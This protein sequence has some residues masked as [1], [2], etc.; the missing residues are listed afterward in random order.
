MGTATFDPQQYKTTTR[1]QWESAAD[2][3]DR[4]DPTLTDW[5]G[6]ATELGDGTMAL[7]LDLPN[8]LEAS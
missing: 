7:I 2:A 6:G 1:A 8:L 3:W 4:W 5:L